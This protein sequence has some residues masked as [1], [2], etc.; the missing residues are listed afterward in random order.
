MSASTTTHTETNSTTKE[1]T[2]NTKSTSTTTEDQAAASAAKTVKNVEDT[3][4][5]ARAEKIRQAFNST[6]KYATIVAAGVG[7]ALLFARETRTGYL[8]PLDEN[9]HQEEVTFP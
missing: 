2:V 7:S 8:P 1:E 9:P 5:G 3:T 4:A 6:A